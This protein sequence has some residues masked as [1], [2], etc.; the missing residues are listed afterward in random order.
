[1]RSRTA[2]RTTAAGW[3][4]GSKARRGKRISSRLFQL[5]IMWVNW[6][7]VGQ[8]QFSILALAIVRIL[9][10]TAKKKVIQTMENIL[11]ILDK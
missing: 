10:F 5:H 9:E 1:M 8:N 2:Q 7:L 4:G 3:R 11:Y 6:R